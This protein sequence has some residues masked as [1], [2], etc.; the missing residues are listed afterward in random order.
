MERHLGGPGHHRH[1]RD[2]AV[3][4]RRLPGHQGLHPL[5]LPLRLHPDG[6]DGA[7]QLLEA[8]RGRLDGRGLVPA[9]GLAYEVRPGHPPCHDRRQARRVHLAAHHLPPR[10]RLDHRLPDAQRPRADDGRRVLPGGRAA[11]RLRLQLV[12]RGLPHRR[13]LQQRPEPGPRGR[14][15]RRAARQGRARVRM[16]GLRPRIQHGR[17]HPMRPS[18]RGRPGRTTT[19][20]GTTG[21]PGTTTPPPSA[22]APSTG[23]TCSTAG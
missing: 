2:R 13:L 6:E 18:I 22:S 11:H 5:P 23:A 9:P 16:A 1:V 12:L 17:V 19:S 4:A 3:R 7:H 8:V 15:R 21:R 14:R 20:R 10:G